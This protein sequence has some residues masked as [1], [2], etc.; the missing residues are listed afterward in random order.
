MKKENYLIGTTVPFTP[1]EIVINEYGK[2]EKCIKQMKEA[3]LNIVRHYGRFPFADETM[4]ELSQD[5]IEFRDSVRKYASYGIGTLGMILN[6]GQMGSDSKG[7]VSYL[8]QYPDWMGPTD[9]DYYYEVLAKATE[10][11]AYDLKDDITYWQIGNEQDMKTFIGDLTIEQNERWMNVAAQAV[12]KGNSNALCGTNFAGTNDYMTEQSISGYTKELV[13]KLYGCPDSVYDFIGL[14]GYFGSWVPGGTGDWKKY[15]D[16]AYE[17][18]RK[19][20]LIQE[21]GYSTLQQGN[22]RT[23]EDK[24]RFFNTVV[25]REKSWGADSKHRWKGLPHSEETQ[26]DYIRECAKLFY[27]HPHCMGQMFFQWQDQANCW[28]CGAPDCP[29]ECAWGCVRVDGT[30]KSG[31]YALKEVNQIYK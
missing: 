26:C 6:P 31:Y 7:N 21:W 1:P 11:V 18:S 9:Q 16:E 8:R 23:P 20:V 19:P 30:P 22:P 5:Y 15:I 14:D 2:T 3:E 12:K 4:T 27:E 28:Q 10:F 13:N 29:A 25:C 24:D 17:I